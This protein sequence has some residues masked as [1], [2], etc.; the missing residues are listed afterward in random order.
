MT[1]R[2]VPLTRRASL[3]LFAGLG[4]SAC[5]GGGSSPTP[6]PAP[7]P[8]PTPTPTPPPSTIYHVPV[9]GQSNAAGA[10]AKPVL[11]GAASPWG[12]LM[13]SQGVQTWDRLKNPQAPASRPATDFALVGLVAIGNETRA[14][15]LADRL[16]SEVLA[17]R[18][19]VLDRH[20]VLVSDVAEGSRLLTELGPENHA[21]SGEAGAL[22]PGG[23]WPTMLD[24]IERARAG[25]TAR[26]ANF[27]VPFWNYDQGE[28]ERGTMNVYRNRPAVPAAQ[29]VADYAARAVTMVET[30]DREMRTR[31]GK[32]APTPCL[33]TPACFNTLTPTAWLDA[34]DAS[35]LAVVVGPRYQMPSAWLATVH[36][37]SAIH[38][39]ADGQRWIGEMVAKVGARVM[40]GEA[41]QPMRALRATRV[42]ATE[43]DVL[44]HVPRGSIVLDTE[45]WPTIEGWGFGLYTGPVGGWARTLPTSLAIVDATTIRLQFPAIPAGAKLRIGASG[46]FEALA[47]QPIVAVG[48]ATVNGNPA[49]AITLQGDHSAALDKALRDGPVSA[50]GQS[51]TSVV[52]R[53]YELAGGRTTLLGA[54][55]EIYRPGTFTVGERLSVDRAQPAT[56]VRDSDDAVSLYRFAQG[57]RAGQAYPLYNWLATYDGLPVVGA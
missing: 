18:T 43:V 37:D 31:L 39:C 7:T 11:S 42:S 3:A 49:V 10:D 47:G 16:K 29:L 22:A 34:S 57:P 48:N 20:Q 35:P 14:T 53:R 25:A 45:S 13:F 4:L 24:D 33:V 21:A 50:I 23:F 46:R 30:F 51:G 9:M 56:N 55:A 36:P 54:T 6:S 1:G 8:P 15:G 27:Q 19:P 5:G 52:I 41:W 2:N 17:T 26:N 12:N 38:Y 28:A 40:G 32:A 44:L